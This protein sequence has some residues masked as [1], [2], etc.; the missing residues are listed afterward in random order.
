MIKIAIID[1]HPLIVNGLENILR[2]HAEIEIG[3][4]YTSVSDLLTS[5][6][7]LQ[8]D[9]LL[10]DIQMPEKSGPELAKIIQQKYP[11]IRMIA[12]TNLDHTFY[13]KAM[14]RHSVLGYVLKS[15]DQK[16]LL[17]AIQSV[18]EHRT[19]ID[20]E[21]EPQLQEDLSK[22]RRQS[23]SI[24]PLTRREREILVL[25]ANEHTTQEIATMLFLSTNT[26]ETHRLNLLTKLDVKNTAGLVKKAMQLGLVE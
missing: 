2:H 23:H 20:P 3:G 12:L 26:I 15:S 7:T 18:H 1:D 11:E 19:Y 8:V 5:L 21:I 24:P 14:L 22:T 17:E 10:I 25:I 6:P 16:I 9:V 4:C 13:A